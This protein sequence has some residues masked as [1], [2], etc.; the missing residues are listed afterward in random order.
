[1][2]SFD[3]EFKIEPGSVV[4]FLEGGKPKI[5]LVLEKKENKLR[6]LTLTGKEVKLSLNRLLPWIGPQVSLTLSREDK[7]KFLEERQREREQLASKIVLEK[8]W[9]LIWEE[10]REVDVFWLAELYF[11]QPSID[12]VAALGRLLISNKVFFKYKP[13]LFIVHTQEEVEKLR[14]E[15]YKKALLAKVLAEGK[16][17]VKEAI[18]GPGRVKLE[19]VSP[20][21]VSTLKEV[22][23]SVLAKKGDSKQ[24]K[25]F[26]QLTQGLADDEH[27]SFILAKNL[28]FIPP[29]FNYLLLQAGYE[30]GRSWEKEYEGVIEELSKKS[31]NLELPVQKN[32]FSVDAPTT[33]DI[34]DA[35]YFQKQG[36]NFHLKVA[37]ACPALLWPF[38][39]PLDLKVRERFSS[40]YLPE[41]SYYLLPYKLATDIFSLVENKQRLALIFNFLLSSK[42]EILEFSF[43][44]G[45]VEVA[46]NLTYEQVDKFIETKKDNWEDLY[47]LSQNL[48]QRR[49]QAG[50]IVVEQA[51]PEIILHSKD[52]EDVAVELVLK[53]FSFS[54]LVVS[55]IMIL[56]NYWAAKWSKENEVPLIY[57]TQDIKFSKDLAGVWRQPQD[58][59]QVVKSMAPSI[60]DLKPNPHA[61]LG[62]EC[63]AP[64][65][66]PLRRYVDLLN[67]AQVIKKLSEE[68][69][70]FTLNELERL[71]PY[72]SAR[73]SLVG[74]VQ[75]F[76][77]RY[78]KLLYFKQRHK[79][80]KFQGVLVEKASPLSVFILPK[81]QILVRVPFKLIQEKTRVGDVCLLTFGRVDP[82]R[83]E[84]RVI[85]VYKDEPAVS[86]N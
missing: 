58:I 52:E 72:L 68:K 27:L 61:C 23:F 85:D 16:E 71:L 8:L 33:K 51:E 74:Q 11:S 57:R 44:L 82:L 62:V 26:K 60:L 39:S 59:Y 77:P 46:K 42:G 19:S 80:E 69:L 17:I 29:H 5:S 64:I 78:W 54:H 65:T 56:C 35:F 53:S 15:Q 7:I 1:M 9:E 34:D 13:P 48:R 75:K 20:E 40:L 18:K 49:I 84:I 31:N 30:A 86:V 63:Y 45:L 38:N 10:V 73:Q 6:L 21:V 3:S 47:Q 32:F 83:N 55:E 14:E 50:A 28:G 12:E 66:S 36:E 43:E 81:E 70:Q 25:V 37:I 2:K 24:E 67:Q 22:L 76:R 79:L 4:E 41:A